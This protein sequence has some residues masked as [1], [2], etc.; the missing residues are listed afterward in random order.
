MQRLEVL[1]QLQR[2]RVVRARARFLVEARHGFEVVVHDV[3]RRGIEDAQRAVQAA[4]EVRREDLDARFRRM[5]AHMADALD[6]VAGTAV[7][8]V[9]AVDAGDHHVLKAQRADRLGQVDRLVR[10]ERIGAAVADV[11]E[12]AAP[13]ALVAHDH[14]GRRALAETLADVRAARFLAHRVQVVLAQDGLDL[15][16]A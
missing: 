6:E 10:I 11:A 7:A 4:A 2:M 5:L 8:Q 14:E 13:R 1:Q 15:V 12:R 3:G 16:E 9:V